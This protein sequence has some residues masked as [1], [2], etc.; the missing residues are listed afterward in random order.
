ML[1]MTT[2]QHSTRAVTLTTRAWERSH[3]GRPRGHGL[4]ALQRSTSRT[5]L[6]HELHGPVV[7]LTGT[8]T[9][10]RQQLA[11]Q[12]ETGLWAVLS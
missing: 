3:P 1:R 12:G 8:L 2:T 4:W 5:A 10:C 11:A 9:S 6:Q 7:M